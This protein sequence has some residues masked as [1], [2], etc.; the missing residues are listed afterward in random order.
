MAAKMPDSK[1]RSFRVQEFVRARTERA[2]IRGRVL[3][4]LA[5]SMLLIAMVAA[6]AIRLADRADF[7]TFGDG[8][9]WAIVTLGTVGYGDLVPH[10]APGRVIG[11]LVILFGVTAI[12]MLTAIV[13]SYFVSTKQH[14]EAT[15]PEKL[16]RE[17]EVSGSLNISQEILERLEAIE[18]TLEKLRRDESP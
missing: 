6:V 7:P 1:S 16:G 8:L 18:A 3:P 15:Q 10:N 9:W 13:T 4:Y 17:G 14:G 5:G 2:I 11:S 12:A